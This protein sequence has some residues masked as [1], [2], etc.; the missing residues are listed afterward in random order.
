MAT[1]LVADDDE[2]LARML[3]KALLRSGHQVIR[4]ANGVEALRLYDPAKVDLVLTDLIMPEK[5]GLELIM[6]LRK[7]NK[8][9]KII[10]M[11]GGGRSG[12][13]NYLPIAK[14]MGSKAV[15]KKPFSIELL[16]QTVNQILA[17]STGK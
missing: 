17:E 4:A 16:Q 12:P 10:A 15:L 7:I 2:L 13:E 14:Q 11:S 5:E 1:I 8:E 3:E 6:S 9:I